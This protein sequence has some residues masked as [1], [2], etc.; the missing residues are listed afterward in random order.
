MLNLLLNPIEEKVYNFILENPYQDMT[1]ISKSCKLHRPLAYKT[2]KDLIKKKFILIQLNGK[3]K[4]YVPENPSKIYDEFVNMEFKIKNLSRDLKEK[5]N[6]NI[7]KL[8]VTE[9]NGKYAIRSA[10]KEIIEN[11]KVK[12]NFYRIESLK[13]NASLKVYYPEIYRERALEDGD[14]NK[15]VITST[16]KHKKRRP[17]LNRYS[18]VINQEESKFEDNVFQVVSDKNVLFVDLNSEQAFLFEGEKFAKFQRSV[19]KILYKRL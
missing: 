11:T 7:N 2:I 16:A 4:L 12:H 19:F 1:D 18:K 17:A 9:Y 13:E 10:F 14:I 8:K 5:Y 15:Y 6:K 3:K